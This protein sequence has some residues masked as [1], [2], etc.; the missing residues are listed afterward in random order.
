MARPEP[1][2]TSEAE[3]RSEFRDNLGDV[4][5][6]SA[7]WIQFGPSVWVSNFSAQVF[8][9]GLRGLKI[10][11]PTGGFTYL[12]VW[13]GV[14]KWGLFHPF[15]C[16]ADSDARRNGESDLPSPQR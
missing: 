11:D 7:I 3:N 14:K 16:C 2:Q 5:L 1:V 15:F 6:S 9:W 12:Y 10:S 13:E 4:A 8:F